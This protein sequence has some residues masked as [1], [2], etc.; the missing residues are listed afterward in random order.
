MSKI[1]NSF[2]KFF[3]E[4]TLFFCRIPLRQSKSTM[5]IIL[6][7]GFIFNFSW[8]SAV[9]ANIFIT[10]QN[11]PTNNT[12]T[13]EVSEDDVI[14]TEVDFGETLVDIPVTKTFQVR[15]FTDSSI[16]LS[17]LG[18]SN[19]TAFTT[20]QLY[21]NTINAGQSTI[22]KVM[23][24]AN[25]P[26][27]I[28]GGIFF[29]GSDATNTSPVNI[30]TRGIVEPTPEIEVL[31]DDTTIPDNTG[32]VH[33]DNPSVK[34]HSSK[35]F[36]V[37]NTGTADLTLTSPIKIEGTTGFV[38]EKDFDI[39]T[40]GVEDSTTFK[41]K[42]DTNTAGNFIG[43]VSFGN[44]D[45]DE[46]P[47]NFFLTGTVIGPEIEVLELE[48]ALNIA[49]E[50]GHLNF[51]STKVGTDI[52]KTF[53]VKNVGTADLVL[54][55]PT[56]EGIGFAIEN[57]FEEISLAPQDSITYK[58]KLKSNTAGHFEGG[59]SFNNN[60][61][62]E[63]PFSFSFTGT[64]IGPE[65][66]VL[67]LGNT[68]NIANEISHIDFGN[69]EIGIDII[70]IFEVKNVGNANLTLTSPII[71]GTGFTVENNL[72]E[73]TLEAGA[74]T[75]F[76]IK[77]NTNTAGNFKGIVSFNNNDNDES[78]YSFSLTGTVL[79]PEIEV[80]EVL[81]LEETINI[82][83]GTSHID[84]GNT[85]KNTD[86]IKTFEVKNVGNANLT[87]TSPIIEGTG[88]TVENSFEEMTLA[89][90]ESITYEIKLESSTAGN[91]K[92]VISF[93]NNDSD[94]NPYN[95]SLSGSV[96]A[97]TPNITDCT[98]Q[99]EISTTEC[100]ALIDFYNQTNG[101]NWFD[102]PDNNWNLT[103]APCS[104]TG[105]TC[106]KRHVTAIE[107]NEQ[108][109]VGVL[110]N[111]DALTH[112]Q[113]ISLNNN[114]LT[115]SIPNL[116]AV[117]KLKKLHLKGNQLTE[118]IPKLATLQQLEVL[119]LQNNQLTG[120]SGD[121]QFKKSNSLRQLNLSNNQLSGTLPDL[122]AFTLL[123]VLNLS[124]N[125]LSDSIGD[126]SALSN[127]STLRLDNN[128]LSGD[129]P[130]SFN[131]LINLIDLDL[132][133]NKLTAQDV[134]V[135]NFINSK[136]S[137]WANTQTIPP[138]EVKA[139][140]LQATK[141]LLEWTP[142]LYTTDGGYYQ[143]RYAT[144]QE[145]FYMPAMTITANKKASSFE[146][147]GL[148]PNTI[149]HFVVETHTPAHKPNQQN[150]L[151]SNHS[152]KVS[153][154]TPPLA[155][156]FPP[157][158]ESLDIGN[159]EPEQPV[160]AILTF[161]NLGTET[162][163]V[164]SSKLSNQTGNF[165]I[166]SEKTAFSIPANNSASLAVECIPTQFGKHTAT[167]TLTTNDSYCPTLTYSL[168]CIG[169][170]EGP[171][172][173]S[174][175]A[176][177]STL[178]VPKDE[179]GNTTSI[180]LTVLE[181]GNDML[182][183][184]TEISGIH[185]TDFSL[186]KGAERFSIADGDPAHKLFVRCFPT[187]V[188]ERR[189]N[190]T[191]ATNA[192]NY[193][194]ITYPLICG[195]NS[196]A[197]FEG[198]IQT[199]KEIGTNLVIDAPEKIKLIGRIQPASQHV[200]QKADIMMIYHW[201]PE[202]GGQSLT[203]KITVTKKPLLLL[204]GE[205]VEKT[206]FEGRLI[207]LTGDFN[208][209]LGYQLETGE[210]VFGE[211]LQLKVLPNHVPIKI[212]L[213]GNTV[214]ENT[215]PNTPI[216]TFQTVEYLKGDNDDEFTYGIVKSSVETNCIVESFVEMGK[217]SQYFTENASKYFTIVNNELRTGQFT[218]DFETVQ[219]YPIMVRSVD[220]SGACVEQAFSIY[221]T[222]RSCEPEEIR[223]IPFFPQKKLSIQE[224]SLNNTMIGQII[225]YDRKSCKYVL[226][227]TQ[228]RFWLDSD[229]RLRVADSKL[230]GDYE[231]M[232]QPYYN[233][234]IRSMNSETEEEMD[235]KTFTIELTNMVDA[236]VANLYNAETDETIESPINATDI[237]EI[238][239]QLIPDTTHHGLEADIVSATM[240]IQNGEIVFHKL[241]DNGWQ[242]W[243][244][245]IMTLS[246]TQTLT[247]ITLQNSHDIVLPLLPAQFTNFEG[248]EFQIYVGY[249]LIDT[250]ELVYDHEPIINIFSN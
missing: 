173:D 52:I 10:F 61:N 99:K 223:L 89:P 182:T 90:Q 201:T 74:S 177:G 190:L 143:V 188:G 237:K 246:S 49:N 154:T 231:E 117:N 194:T 111:W 13:N 195:E 211:I 221:V 199:N 25:T 187:S 163:E 101:S 67:E 149:Y 129:I 50:T 179:L 153:V 128:Q 247:Q 152:T 156:S 170:I 210:L 112:L 30:M 234:T 59:V 123:E 202:N 114:Q 206:L 205:K 33:F 124:A 36:T 86:I 236:V 196:V 5:F 34:I 209:E 241:D 233:I 217:V 197:T 150:A 142:V 48:D 193:S 225:A 17:S 119:D 169:E 175:P 121:L 8:I 105:I 242:P 81:E 245:N 181:V 235:D 27:D 104:W 46:N 94:E 32:S 37:K 57:S 70:K 106:T 138:T 97:T 15:N 62:D 82:A 68:I 204:E 71:D 125:Q 4:R 24:N 11:S 28:I 103:N 165:R 144:N 12:L 69:T 157:V 84:F 77:L 189:A 208:I 248:D 22:F 7:M 164:F 35:I 198:E 116:S 167:L 239:V 226:D 54:T 91:F 232:V 58:I 65:I 160:T 140:A 41:I 88:F 203:G 139:T 240:Y 40:L 26:G 249:R 158:S 180:S 222:N 20:V 23:L 9:Q 250:G 162:R 55:S 96:I 127:L 2:R 220:M 151:V 118:N 14:I 120:F 137:D 122:S 145:E 53:E 79:G 238:K 218:L 172:Y 134:K 38:V 31:Q 229:L 191:L 230:L 174:T 83:N 244:G 51:G 141:V 3:P 219:E 64:V 100:N 102:S 135:I 113:K 148:L 18:L 6:L 126:L 60:D 132:G 207:G 185:A 80:I 72:E 110:P 200:G 183:V 224:K 166:S 63:T 214:K 56:I 107:R 92:G 76:E 73:M 212:I 178:K 98:T 21:D 133:Y 184:E 87:L 146:V 186:S 85:E 130:A 108:N 44:S 19:S 216:G 95:F 93:G 192:L 1:V 115:G 78:P 213:N 16:S 147:T 75:T 159:S 45:N 176:P 136:D 29:D 155:C 168:R 215:L 171:G 43:T 228:N 243:N 227:N 131:Q 161:E 66:E 47:Y 109:L 39:N 42:L